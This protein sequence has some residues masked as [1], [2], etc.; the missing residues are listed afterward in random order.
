MDAGYDTQGL[1][2]IQS[3]MVSKIRA[4]EVRSVGWG[5]T[6]SSSK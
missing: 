5:G 1:E 4:Q 3:D 2:G 6:L